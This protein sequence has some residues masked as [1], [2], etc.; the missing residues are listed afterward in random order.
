M[1]ISEKIIMFNYGQVRNTTQV[2]RF[3]GTKYYAKHPR[4]VLQL[5]V[6]KI[7]SAKLNLARRNAHKQEPRLEFTWNQG[8]SFCNLWLV[9]PREGSDSHSRNDRIWSPLP[10]NKVPECRKITG[11]KCMGWTHKRQTQNRNRKDKIHIVI[12]GAI[13]VS[14]PRN[15]A[16]WESACEAAP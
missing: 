12:T 2:W 8:F 5:V 1:V 3:F 4:K 6:F 9:F 16:I 13:T 10:P 11:F 7:A 14:R 15:L